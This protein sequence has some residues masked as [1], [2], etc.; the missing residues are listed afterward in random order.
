MEMEMTRTRALAFTATWLLAAIMAGAQEPSTTPFGEGWKRVVPVPRPEL[1]EG[2]RYLVWV[3]AGWLQARRETAKGVT[4]WHVV[5]AQ[6]TGAKPPDITAT[7]GTVRFEV[8]Y[9]GGRYFVREDANVLRSLRE[10]KPADKGAWPR[11]SFPQDRYRPTGSAG[12]PDHPPMLRGWSGE[13][14]FIITS[15]A[16]PAEDRVDCLVR[17]SPVV[18][19]SGYGYQFF[20]GSTLR[21][22]FL[23]EN[24]VLDDGELLIAQRTLETG[25]L[26][27][28]EVGD[29]AP[30]LAAKTLDGKS[31]K[32]ED[33]RGRYVLLDYWATWCTPCVAELPDLKEVHAA[34]GN[35]K[36]FVMIGLSLDEETDAPRKFVTERGIP[37]V[38]VS[39]GSGSDN[40]VAR[41]YGVQSIPATFLIGPDGKVI[42]KGMRGKQIK[43]VVA[44][45]LG[46][47]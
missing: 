4:D 42:A 41:D 19:K 40:S 18:K 2:D 12:S 31:L 26:G 15:S 13:E 23:G 9:G 7:E 47:N 30:P 35:D 37:W 29:P 6:A 38:Q 5:L 43:E 44:R 39:L 36:R 16:G 20:Q 11:V 22:A 33:Y 14:G 3:E 32:L 1:G 17:L 27:D 45:A 24:W 21:R 46:K 8:S 28:V 25:V 10:R 34:F